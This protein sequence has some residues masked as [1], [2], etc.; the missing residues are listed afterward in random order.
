M[1]FLET[2]KIIILSKLLLNDS[3]CVCRN[4]PVGIHACVCLNDGD[5]EGNEDLLWGVLLRNFW[6][7]A[8]QR[9]VG[10]VFILFPLQAEGL[11]LC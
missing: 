5:P 4:T 6:T 9:Y 10:L 2:S 8:L 11:W 1:S 3:V 7:C